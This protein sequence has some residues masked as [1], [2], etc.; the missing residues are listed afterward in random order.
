MTSHCY[1]FLICSERSGSN[2]ITK[3][4][5]GHP[6]I[7]GPSPIHLLR[8][9][10]P[11]EYRYG[12]LTELDNWQNLT[13]DVLNFFNLKISHWESD[14]TLKELA[15]LSNRSLVSLFQHIYQTEA[16]FSGKSLSF[17]K[18]NHAYKLAP[19][20]M[21]NFPEAKYIWS[22]RD[23]RDM[24]LSWKRDAILRG[25]IVRAANVWKEDQKMTSFFYNTMVCHDKVCKV[26]YET[27]TSD[28]EQQSRKICNFLDLEY[29]PLMA[30][31]ENSTAASKNAQASIGWENLNKGVLKDNSRKYLTGLD[32]REIRFIEY[33]CHDEMSALGYSFE[34][35]RVDRNEFIHLQQTL[36]QE[37]QFEKEAYQAVS[38]EEKAKRKAW[39]TCLNRIQKQF[40]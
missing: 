28:I 23:P 11:I 8:Y 30:N 5:D 40:S 16:S 32:D 39:V 13:A 10:V 36:S 7:S 31:L 38:D 27:L 18:E 37:E 21:M 25:G 17:V 33:L 9:F 29:S 15:G 12:P 2:F 24:A 6:E 14:F 22:Y 35:P 20:Y 19:F 1:S 4:L 34:F 26:S 3:L